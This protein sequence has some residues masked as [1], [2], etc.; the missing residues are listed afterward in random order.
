ML[1]HLVHLRDGLVHFLDTVAL[2]LRRRRDLAHDIGH[3]PDRRDDQAHGLPRLVHQA[4]AGIDL[5]DRV[6]DQA[7]DFLRCASRSLRQIAHF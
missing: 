6:A 5:V 4:A 1:R 3:L 2:F 7:L